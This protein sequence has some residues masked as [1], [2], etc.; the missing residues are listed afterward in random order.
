MTI[1]PCGLWTDN[2]TELAGMN[3]ICVCGWQ[4]PPVT[5]A[6]QRAADEITE[7]LT[8]SFE[9]GPQTQGLRLNKKD[10]QCCVHLNT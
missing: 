5:Q 9:M 7:L 1:H 8:W 6:K 4:E 3:R 2:V 10:L